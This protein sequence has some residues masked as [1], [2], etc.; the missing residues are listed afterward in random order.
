VG[1]SDRLLIVI[2]IIDVLATLLQANLWVWG[3]VEEIQ[4][5]NADF[6]KIQSGLELYRQIKEPILWK[7]NLQLPV[8]R[9][10]EDFYA[11]CPRVTRLNTAPYIY[12]YS[13]NGSTYDLEH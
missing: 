1:Y 9:H 10:L 7:P 4:N 13:S 5:A 12:K 3:C 6:A 2:A 11:E 8:K